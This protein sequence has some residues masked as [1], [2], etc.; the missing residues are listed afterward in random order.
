MPSPRS[1]SAIDDGEHAGHHG[2]R[3]LQPL[4]RAQRQL[5]L[6]LVPAQALRHQVV[7]AELVRIDHLDVR[8]DLLHA[9]RLEHR[10]DDD[11]AAVQLEVGER[12]ED[13]Q[14]DLV[15]QRRRAERVRV[16]QDRF[17]DYPAPGVTR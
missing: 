14:R 6:R 1:R 17:H 16:D 11:A 15:A 7:P 5:D 8:R 13:R 4:A 12:V 9:V 3:H 10:D 2:L